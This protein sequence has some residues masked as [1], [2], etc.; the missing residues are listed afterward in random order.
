M[1]KIRNII[2]N[3]GSFMYASGVFISIPILAYITA[4]VASMI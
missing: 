1:R 3:Y 2:D 4:T